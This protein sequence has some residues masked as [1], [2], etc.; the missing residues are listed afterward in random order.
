VLQIKQ[1]LIKHLPVGFD[2]W[3]RGCVPKCYGVMK[4]FPKT[5]IDMI[6]NYLNL[7]SPKTKI[8]FK[9]KLHVPHYLIHVCLPLGT[10][11]NRGFPEI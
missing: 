6:V 8:L 9:R 11:L 1:F 10:L 7:L 4:H 2:F 5:Y 3:K